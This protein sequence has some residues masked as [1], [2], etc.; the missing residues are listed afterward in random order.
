MSTNNPNNFLL[1]FPEVLKKDTATSTSPFT[2]DDLGDFIE[3]R[4][5]VKRIADKF[6]ENNL[7]VDY[8]DFANHVFFDS[9][10]SKFAIAKNKVLNDYPYNGTLEEKDSFHLTGSNYDQYIFD[11]WPRYVGYV[12][13]SASN[14][15]FIS[16]SDSSSK[17]YI[18]SSSFSV[19]AWIRPKISTQNIILQIMSSSIS[20]ENKYGYDLF[21]SGTTDPHI[22]FTLYSGSEKV[23]L[24]SAYINYTGSFNNVAAIFDKPTNL[25]SL[26]INGIRTTSGS[27]S[28]GPIETATL[29]ILVGSGSQFNIASSSYDFYSG[30]I[31]EVRVLLTASELFHS[32]N[33]NRPIDSESYVRLN[34]RFNEGITGTS[35]I[36]SVVVDYSKSGLHGIFKNYS[37]SR[38]SGAVMF[39][40]PGDVILYPIHSDVI[41]FTSSLEL[42]ATLHDRGNNNLIFNFIPEYILREDEETEDLLR[43][44][45]LAMARFFD[46][47]KLYI[48]Q[49]DNLKVTNYDDVDET[50]DI[51]L[52]LLKKYFGWQVSDH[53][54]DAHPLSFFFGENVIPSGSMEVSLLEIRNQ[55]WRRTLNNL[56]YLLKTKGKRHNLDAFL[57]V[58]GINKENINI[59]EF[60]F[61]PGSAIQNSRIHKEKVFS[62]M[63]I[64]TGSLGVLSSSYACVKSLVTDTNTSYTVETLMQL[65]FF[66]ASYSGSLLTGSVWEFVNAAQNVGYT[67]LW[68]VTTLGST[69]GK[70]ILTGSDGQF[71]SSSN[72]EV[73]DGDLTYV[74]AGLNSSR[75]PFIEIRTI[76]NDHI[77]FSSS[78]VGVLAFSGVFTG[79]NLDFVM[80]SNSGSLFTKETQGYY[81]EYRVWRRP[82]SGS[83]INAHAL[84]F[85]NVGI[86]DPLET[87]H[88]LRGHW[89]LTD[90][91]S[92]DSNGNFYLDDY[93]RNNFFATGSNF[94][95]N[96]NPFHKFLHEY[97][98]LSPSFDLKWTEDKIRIRNKSSLKISDIAYDTN[99][100]ALEF[101]LI[102]S[103][104]QDI[105]KIFSTLDLLN[106]YIG[107]PIFKYRDEYS[108]LENLRRLYFQ[109]LGEGVNFNRFFGLFQ[110]FDNKISESIK[111]LLPA[112]VKFVG[113][114][115][116]IESHMLERPRY[117][118]QYPVF[119]TPVKIPENVLSGNIGFSGS[120]MGTFENSR[121]TVGTYVD[122]DI[123]SRTKY[124][125]AVPDNT[126]VSASFC[127]LPRDTSI[128]SDGYVRSKKRMVTTFGDG[129]E[130]VDKLLK[131]GIPTLEIFGSGSTMSQLANANNTA[132][133]DNYSKKQKLHIDVSG[134]I[135]YIFTVSSST[136][137][138]FTGS[139]FNSFPQVMGVMADQP[140]PGVGNFGGLATDIAIDSSGAIY[141]AGGYLTSSAFND[142][143]VASNLSS[144]MSVRKGHMSSSNISS[145]WSTVLYDLGAENSGA[146]AMAVTVDSNDHIYVAGGSR[147]L[148]SSYNWYIKKSID[149]GSTWNTVFISGGLYLS[150]TNATGF[151]TAADL[152]V[153]IK[154]T[155][156]G[157]LDVYATGYL[158]SGSQVTVWRTIKSSDSGSTWNTVDTFKYGT[159]VVVTGAMAT[160]IAFL[161]NNIYVAG[162]LYGG[163][164]SGTS[165]QSYSLIRSSSDNGTTWGIVYQGSGSG[166]NSSRKGRLGIGT[167]IS[168]NNSLLAVGDYNT[169]LGSSLG[170]S[171]SWNNMTWNMDS[172]HNINYKLS[173]SFGSIAAIN[174][175]GQDYLFVGR[176]HNNNIENGVVYKFCDNVSFTDSVTLSQIADGNT[177]EDIYKSNNSL[178]FKNEYAK[179]LLMEKDRDNN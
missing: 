173:H 71:L 84:H 133:I 37:N 19:S 31:N 42:S 63:G 81:G 114:E 115:Q 7:K 108:D 3:E 93:S 142:G 103:L 68:N 14:Q 90:D 179:R 172:S 16:A 49:F 29:N 178:N 130:R 80:G 75:I 91:K 110:W 127:I 72:V 157:A 11:S 176:G 88:P 44:F 146:L 45:T 129:E 137:R 61:L 117:K 104:N 1:T 28:F 32:K 125:N 126:D 38:I 111:Q 79:S 144:Y 116:V 170:A 150:G 128:I 51:F 4:N 58:L 159:D 12:N 40:D 121:S 92:T 138:V 77:D 132:F 47:Q 124:S 70:F 62:L 35:S 107:K 6:L 160:S 122:S 95:V 112:R 140:F 158:A 156:T 52:P 141:V 36:D 21:L 119:R 96:H 154:T 145:S 33:F 22:K 34:Y 39:E 174:L 73:F 30:S 56:P 131:D 164:Y 171:G 17:L 9:A 57:N 89:P 59:K 46:E 26:Y 143:A 78:A 166:F 13:L 25:L 86:N 97:N 169:V 10:V 101:N 149:R 98:Y 167:I 23:S 50:A 41:A 106:D 20:L 105:V 87:P 67:L 177:K 102:D 123:A 27:V 65:P 85:E 69:S 165:N 109:R 100:L 76:D 53:F 18:G 64:G 24:S 54:N 118:Y 83:E 175:S 94:S 136:W 15:Q 135:Y 162:N 55:F 155:Q 48:D 161:N 153:D 66:S 5:K 148:S 2:F 163:T 8:S 43:P 120:F 139:I 99:E 152:I 134:T 82:L 74:A 168:F 113:G 147:A 151:D 60:G